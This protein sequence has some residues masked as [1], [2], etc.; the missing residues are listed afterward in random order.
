MIR[1]NKYIS[2]DIKCIRIINENTTNII[3]KMIRSRFII[4]FSNPLKIKKKYKI[5]NQPNK[6]VTI[7][8][9]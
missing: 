6:F 2:I 1:I 3:L 9:K 5:K 7:Y 4:D 8:Q